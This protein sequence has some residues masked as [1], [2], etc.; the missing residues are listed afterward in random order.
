MWRE[1]VLTELRGVGW[2]LLEEADVLYVESTSLSFC[3]QQSCGSFASLRRLVYMRYRVCCYS[4]Y[5]GSR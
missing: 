3:I 5:T 1:R 2:K 4:V